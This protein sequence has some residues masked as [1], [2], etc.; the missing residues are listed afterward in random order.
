MLSNILLFLYRDTTRFL[1]ACVRLC[2]GLNAAVQWKPQFDRIKQRGITRYQNKVLWFHAASVGELEAFLPVI[3]R[4]ENTSDFY[5]II[6]VFSKSAFQ[7]LMNLRKLSAESRV[8]YKGFSPWEGQW[9]EALREF[10]PKIFFTTKYEAW[11]DLWAS[12]SKLQI[13]LWVL[14]AKSRKSLKIAKWVLIFLRVRLPRFVFLVFKPSAAAGL[15]K[16]FPLSEI[17]ECDEPRWQRVIQRRKQASSKAENLQQQVAEWPKPWTV[18]GSV[19]PE[20][21]MELRRRTELYPEI[22]VGTWFLFPHKLDV[23][24]LKK[25]DI[26]AR[27]LGMGCLN[28]SNDLQAGRSIAYTEGLPRILLIPLHGVLAEFYQYA[29]YAWVGG[30]YGVGVHSTIEPAIY[31]PPIAC[32]PNRTELFDEIKDLE[33]AEQLTVLRD[34]TAWQNWATKYRDKDH[35]E[36]SRKKRSLEKRWTDRFEAAADRIAVQIMERIV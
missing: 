6:T 34:E 10:R 14:G 22:F 18:V 27:E 4:L 12:L 2:L 33:D 15:K 13:P 3:E 17:I 28:F 5:F 29:D 26:E 20:D 36:I 8:I 19:W 24:S 23:L 11:P 30:G 35:S 31:G 16:L 32:G 21:L 1:A 25:I 9:A 7:H